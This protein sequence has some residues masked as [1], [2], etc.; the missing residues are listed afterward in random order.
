MLGSEDFFSGKTLAKHLVAVDY[1]IRKA[2]AV[3]VFLPFTS[4]INESINES[5]KQASKQASKRASKQAS[6]QLLS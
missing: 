6:K 2:T 5:S 1:W 3:L 4:E